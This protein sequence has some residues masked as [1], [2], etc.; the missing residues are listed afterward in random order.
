MTPRSAGTAKCVRGGAEGGAQ[1]QERRA[2][3]AKGWA[4]RREGIAEEGGRSRDRGGLC[5]KTLK[6]RWASRNQFA[7]LK[8]STEPN[9]VWRERW[10][11]GM[12]VATSRRH[13]NPPLL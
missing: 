2:E 5:S 7:F 9:S 4:G 13:R 3:P 12:T 8:G 11:V 10:E 6:K 1:H